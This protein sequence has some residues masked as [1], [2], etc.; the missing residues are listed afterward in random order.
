MG[1]FRR[2][3]DSGSGNVKVS[4]QANVRRLSLFNKKARAQ[5]TAREALLREFYN[6]LNNHDIEAIKAMFDE[7][8]EV[9]FADFDMNTRTLTVNSFCSE[10]KAIFAAFPDARFDMA[11][12]KECDEG[13]V[14]LDGLRARGTHT[15][16]LS[17]GDLPEIAAT[18]LKCVNDKEVIVAVVE[19]NKFTSLSI[20]SRGKTTGP[21]GF[22]KQVA[23][24]TSG[25]Q[26]SH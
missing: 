24:G 11:F 17:I 10:S 8:G 6:A 20:I 2:F 21:L 9:C 4:P 13:R 26:S 22:Y 19:G 15:A 5:E 25:E 23:R 12:I 3:S 7:R 16:A 14:M 1:F 18:N